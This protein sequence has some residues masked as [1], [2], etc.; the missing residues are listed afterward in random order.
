[1]FLNGNN[2][3]EKV[4]FSESGEEREESGAGG[5]GVDESEKDGEKVMKSR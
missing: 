4:D 5:D 2:P 1:M 3:G